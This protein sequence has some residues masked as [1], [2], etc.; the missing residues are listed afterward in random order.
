M[1][2]TVARV[3][4]ITDPRVFQG[5][6]V[7]ICTDIYIPWYIA[8]KSRALSIFPMQWLYY[9][10]EVRIGVSSSTRA[11]FVS[12]VILAFRFLSRDPRYRAVY[13]V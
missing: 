3:G 8:R 6:T 10:Y 12:Y 5:I 11:S 1:D 2:R 9:V 4:V 13:A 7:L